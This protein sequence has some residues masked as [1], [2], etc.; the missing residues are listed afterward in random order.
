MDLEKN[1]QRLEILATEVEE[2]KNSGGGGTVDAYTKE[3]ADTK[4]ATNEELEG[5]VSKTD[6]DNDYIKN[7]APIVGGTTKFTTT[8]SNHD[9]VFLGNIA[10][11]GGN[12]S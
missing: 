9:S 7:A 6:A 5:Y 3:E 10:A 11:N 2:L 12:S 8:P 1:K 4:F